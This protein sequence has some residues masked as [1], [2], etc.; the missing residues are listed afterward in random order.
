MDNN[1]QINNQNQEWF[2]SP[3]LY[4]ENLIYYKSFGSIKKNFSYVSEEEYEFGETRYDEVNETKIQYYDDM[5]TGERHSDV[6]K[7]S[8][9][10]SELI[11]KEWV[12]SLKKINEITLNLRDKEYKKEFL[13]SMISDI[14]FLLKILSKYEEA[15]KYDFIEKRLKSIENHIHVRHMRLLHK[16]KSELDIDK[17]ILPINFQSLD[18]EQLRTKVGKR[19]LKEVFLDL[20]Q[21]FSDDSELK[22]ECIVHLSTLSKLNSQKRLGENN[23]TEF[24]KLSSHALSL[25]D[26]IE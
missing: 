24:N 9:F 20:K 4:F 18:K 7:F 19:Y 3:L 23:D 11:I 8:D 2:E 12:N 6:Q 13:E 17:D 16:S 10:L 22:N 15:R 26:E 1:I 25:I 5:E 14:S 21:Y